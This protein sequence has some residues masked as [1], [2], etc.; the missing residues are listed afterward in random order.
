MWLM[1]GLG[2]ETRDTGGDYHADH[3]TDNSSWS[4]TLRG[5]ADQRLLHGCQD[6]GTSIKQSQGG[7]V[8]AADCQ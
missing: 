6:H 8:A 4:I 1:S 5:A 2:R 3:T 7:C